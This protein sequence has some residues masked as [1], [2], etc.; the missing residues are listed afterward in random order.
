ME[1]ALQLE[2]VGCPTICKHCWAQGV[3][4]PAMPLEDIH[5]VLEEAQQFCRK[6]GLMLSSFPMHELA[7]HPQ[8]PQIMRLYSDFFDG[9]PGF[10][11]LAT[12]GVPIALREDWEEFVQAIGAAGTKTF[13]VAFHGY[14]ADH[15]RLVRREGAFAATCLAVQRIRSLGF[16]CGA[17]V[18]V[19]RETAA[20]F[21]AMTDTLQML[22]LTEMS[23]EPAS[24][25]PTP[26]SWQYEKH[27]P[28]LNALLP[29]AKQV[30]HLS[31]F[32]KEQW[33]N[34]QAYTE[35]AWVQTAQKGNWP[36]AWEPA[37]SVGLVC[38]RNFDVHT[39]KAGLYGQRHGNLQSEGAEEVLHRAVA[40]GYY[41]DERLYLRR[42]TLPP[43]KELAQ[44]MGNAQGQAVHFFAQSM[45]NLWLN[46][47]IRGSRA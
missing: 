5:R 3:P 26:R 32:W 7:A 16:A 2:V 40:H 24:F 36:A 30:Q 28:E 23:W 4:Y 14:G 33:G 15:D 46:R 22:D 31:G 39:G 13:W 19:T 38:R 21:A 47:L 17:N 34:L 42:D 37:D 41:S 9:E 43:T 35:A 6:N 1:L 10:E 44:Q 29:V 20:Q 27:R 8:A 45:R 11:P 25:Y 18:F 12:T